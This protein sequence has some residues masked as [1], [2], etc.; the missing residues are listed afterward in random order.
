MT[1]PL[2]P[3]LSKYIEDEWV[4]LERNQITP[5]A[6]MNAGPPFRC[7]DF[8]GKEIAYQGGGFEGSPRDV[9][10]SRYIEPFLEDITERTVQEI[11][12]LAKDKQQEANELLTEVS[13]LLKSLTRRAY[14]RMATI[15]QRLLGK[16]F[17]E[18]ITLRN[19]DEKFA[20][21]ESFIDQ[22]INAELAMTKRKCSINDFYNNQ[23]FLFWL[24]AL[25]LGAILT[26]AF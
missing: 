24:I 3:I 26:V 20:N 25:L 7:K 23:P 8:Y 1:T 16:G 22:R 5:W 12:N 11:I 9:F 19:L 21:M 18:K 6:F 17:P 4:R 14:D 15:E 13:A 2:Y 10:W